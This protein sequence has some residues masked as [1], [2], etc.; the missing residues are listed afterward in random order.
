MGAEAL[1]ARLL[2]GVTQLLPHLGNIALDHC[3]IGE[4]PTPQDGFPVIGKPAE[5]SGLYVAV[6]HSGITLAPAVGRFAATEILDG[7]EVEML[8]PFR[9][10]RFG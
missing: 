5:V 8:A 2:D 4:R 7:A 6:M 10:G 3:T 9:P 1:T